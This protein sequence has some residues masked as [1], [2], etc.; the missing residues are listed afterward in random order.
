MPC[1]YI[2][3]EWM[4]PAQREQQIVDTLRQLEAQL[5]TGSVQVTISPEGSIAF[6]GWKDRNDVTD[7]CAY[8]RLTSQGSIALLNAIQMA[9][10]MC[11][12]SINTTSINSG[13]HSHDGGKTWHKGH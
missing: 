13:H 7:L 5:T 6:I 8:Q 12:R 1:D 9:E 3:P 10:M 2:R 11:G 4:T